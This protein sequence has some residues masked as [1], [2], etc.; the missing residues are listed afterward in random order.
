MVRSNGPARSLGCATLIAGIL[1]SVSASAE[2]PHLLRLPFDLASLAPAPHSSLMLG[3]ATP[4]LQS[5]SDAQLAALLSQRPALEYS[6]RDSSLKLSLEPG[7]PCTGACLK[8]MG[9]F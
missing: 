9:R 2:S 7:S 1:T 3:A 6:P 8:L 5:P 4:Q